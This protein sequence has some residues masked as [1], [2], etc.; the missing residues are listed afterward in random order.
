MIGCT[1]EAPAEIDPE[2][3]AADRVAAAET[4]RRYFDAY[5]AGDVQ[6]LNEN[7][8]QAAQRTDASPP[9]FPT[10]VHDTGVPT[11]TADSASVPVSMS[12]DGGA[13]PSEP[14]TVTIPLVRDGGRW[15][16]CMLERPTNG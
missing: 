7:S 2:Q 15:V 3:A 9:T 6:A 16:F 11:I 5:N 1:T 10:I 12:I 14:R 4:V 8:C 13:T